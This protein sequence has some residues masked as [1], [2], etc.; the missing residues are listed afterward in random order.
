MPGNLPSSHL[1][2]AQTSSLSLSL[3]FF[4]PPLSIQSY[5]NTHH[6]AFFKLPE[7]RTQTFYEYNVSMH[8]N[9]F[10]CHFSTSNGYFLALSV[11][12]ISINDE[13]DTKQTGDSTFQESIA[14]N[15]FINEEYD[16]VTDDLTFQKNAFLLRDISSRT[17][18]I[19]IL[20]HQ[21]KGAD[22]FSSTQILNFG[23]WTHKLKQSFIL[24]YTLS[25]HTF[26]PFHIY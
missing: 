2:L 16:T 4:P 19:N 21:V 1:G 7:L 3:P 9:I 25:S 26:D 18:C 24:L 10:L 6:F 8:H 23:N 17:K 22:L 20:N 15:I 12:T 13:H 5:P 11:A 14:T